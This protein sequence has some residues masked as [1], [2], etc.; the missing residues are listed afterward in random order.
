ML[1][2]SSTDSYNR[3]AYQR[4]RSGQYLEDQQ[5]PSLLKPFLSVVP[6]FLILRHGGGHQFRDY[7]PLHFPELDGFT[8]HG[9]SGMI[10]ATRSSSRTD[11]SELQNFS[12]TSLK[13]ELGYLGSGSGPGE[14]DWRIPN[15]LLKFF[16]VK[17]LPSLNF[18]MP[19]RFGP[20]LR[21]KSPNPKQHR[22]LLL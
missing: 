12:E 18:A 22:W 19:M 16:H 17:L 7:E 15:R 20:P 1:A 6:N 11:S 13:C 3:S 9:N 10:P 21:E 14:D 4:A 2:N 8:K 5:I